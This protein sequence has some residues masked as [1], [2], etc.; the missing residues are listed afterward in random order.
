MGQR[1][2]YFVYRAPQGRPECL[3]PDERSAIERDIAQ[4]RHIVAIEIDADRLTD[5]AWEMLDVV[6]TEIAQTCDG[7]I[8]APGEGFYDASRNL[9]ARVGATGLD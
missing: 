5:D 3:P 6:E 9:L 2:D 7:I 8:Y 1:V 4:T